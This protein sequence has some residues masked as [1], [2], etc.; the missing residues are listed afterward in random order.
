MESELKQTLGTN[1][2]IRDPKTH[3]KSEEIRWL[4]HFMLLSQFFLSQKAVHVALYKEMQRCEKQQSP[5][6]L[7]SFITWS[8]IVLPGNWLQR[9]ALASPELQNADGWQAG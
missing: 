5:E 7:T 9:E 2:I 1:D 4:K 6:N 3:A 8:L